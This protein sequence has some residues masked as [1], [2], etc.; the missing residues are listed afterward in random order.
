MSPVAP[1]PS[2]G[3]RLPPLVLCALGLFQP[4]AGERVEMHYS[5]DRP[6]VL[7]QGAHD[8]VCATPATGWAAAQAVTLR[9][10]RKGTGSGITTSPGPIA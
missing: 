4:A 5:F 9:L 8:R 7:A 6:F 3:A 2:R 10:W 1:V